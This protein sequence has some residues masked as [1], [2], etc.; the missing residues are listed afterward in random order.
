MPHFASSNFWAA[1]NRL[2]A[3]IRK[4]ADRNYEMLEADS[5]HPSLHLKRVGRFWSVRVSAGYRALGVEAPDGIVWIWIGTHEQYDR[6][7][8][9]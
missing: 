3:E 2:P 6:I 8:R 4:L 1:Y 7:I 5:R 9:S